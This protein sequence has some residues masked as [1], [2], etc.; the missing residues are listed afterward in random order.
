MSLRSFSAYLR[1]PGFWQTGLPLELLNY[2]LA[3]AYDEFGN[4]NYEI[5]KSSDF[6]RFC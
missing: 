2:S 4:V 6:R 5:V 1:F 3:E